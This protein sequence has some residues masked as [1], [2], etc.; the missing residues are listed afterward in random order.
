[1]NFDESVGL[2]REGTIVGYN[3]DNDT[4]E[5]QLNTA[6]AIKGNN[7]ISMPAPAPHALFQNNGLFIGTVPIIG[8]TIVVG[9]GSGNQY[10]FVS[11]RTN[12]PPEVKVG[13]L[14][15]Q[16]TETSKIT[17][18]VFNNIS[19]GSDLNKIHI[20]TGN[21]NTPKTNLISF[22]FENEFHFTQA[23]RNLNGLI[24]RDLKINKIGF[25][26]NTKLENDDYDSSYY[27]IGLDPSAT[28]NDITTGPTKNPPFVETRELVYEFQ[29]QSD[30]TNDLTESAQYGNRNSQSPDYNFP[31]RRKS[32]ADILSLTLLEPNYL[33]ETVKRYSC[34]YI[35]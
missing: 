10:Y 30:I 1:M 7:R 21:I 35:W 26:Q 2:L 14:L 29:D 25:D 31:N 24:K 23:S 5:V 12:N 4:I 34:R 16:S 6:Q 32:R 13:E 20:N 17:L 8:T 11:F 19:I 33:M 3:P 28:S 18:D 22:N 27:I 15:I 9:Q